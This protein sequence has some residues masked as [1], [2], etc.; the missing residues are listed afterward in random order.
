MN[1]TYL[2]I[3]TGLTLIFS[4]AAFVAFGTIS[5]PSPVSNGQIATYSYDDGTTISPASWDVTS[6][7][8]VNTYS[9][10]TTYYVVISWNVSGSAVIH[11]KE[12]GSVIDSK[13]VTINPCTTPV[14]IA[15]SGWTVCGGSSISISPVAAPGS[16]GTGVNW[17]S[18]AS[19][20]SLLSSSTTYSTVIAATTTYYLTTT[21][22]SC[23]SERTP[24]TVTLNP[25]P[26]DTPYSP[27]GASRCGA[28]D[29]SI[30][31]TK[32]SDGEFLWWYTAASGGSHFYSSN[33][34]L[35]II[36]LASTTTYY[37][38][39]ANSYGCESS[40]RLAVTATINPVPNASASNQT[41]CSGQSTSIAISNPNGV[42]GTT[43]SWTQSPLL[44]SGAS[45]G[46]GSTIAQALSCLSNVQGTV[47]YTITPATSLCSGTPINVTATV[48]PVPTVAASGQ[49]LYSG[50]AT[51][52][53][54]T[55]PNGV[56][57]TTFTW[58]QSATNVTGAS[59]G[60][61]TTITQ[62]LGSPINGS[63]VYTITPTANGCT[64]SPVVA[65]VFVGSNSITTNTVLVD[66]VTTSSAVDA[67]AIGSKAQA[68]QYFDGIGR[69]IQT[70]NTKGSPA[71]YDMV[72][73]QV[74]DVFGREPKNYLPFVSTQTTGYYNF[75]PTLNSGGTY[76]GSVHANFYNNS[77]DK[78]EDDTKPYAETI[79]EASP[80]NRV[81]K[82]GAPG[83]AWQPDGTWTYASTDA[84]IKR[85]YQLNVANEVLKWT[86]SGSASYSPLGLIDAGTASSKIY[87]PANTLP[88]NKSKDEHGNEVIEY[89]DKDGHVVL[90]RVQAVGG[91]S[92]VDDNN[93]ASTYYIYSDAGDL[94]CVVPPEATSRLSAEY[95]QSGATNTTKE[96]FLQRWAFRYKYDARKR[97]ALKQ[98][99][100]ADSMRMVYDVRDRVV[101][102]QD[103]NLRASNKWNYTEYDGLNRPIITGLYTHGSAVTQTQMASLVTGLTNLFETY[104]G[105]SSTHGYTNTVFPSG[106]FNVSGFEV[107]TVTYYDN[108]SFK[109]MLADSQ[110]DYVSNDYTD[111]FNIG[112]NPNLNVR[113]LVTG[114]KIKILDQSTYLWRATYFDD[115]NRVVQTIANNSKGGVDRNTSVFDFAGRML[116]NMTIHKVGTVTHTSA[117]HMDYD[118]G[119]RLLRTWHK[120]DTQPDIVLNESQY[121]ELGQL[122]KKSLHAQV[123]PAINSPNT[124]YSPD[125]LT[126]SIYSGQPLAIGRNSVTLAPG[127]DTG[128]GNSFTARTEYT[129][130]NPPS[131]G[132]TYRFAQVIDY[133]YNIRGWLKNINNSNLAAGTTGDPRDFFGMELGYNTNIG[134]SGATLAY[135]G[136]I[137]AATWSVNMA[138]DTLTQ[139][140]YNYKYDPLNRIL[141]A[142]HKE[143]A[144][145]TWSS[146]AAFTERNYAY[147]LNGNIKRLTRFGVGG[148]M[149][150]SLTYDYGTTMSNQLMKVSDNSDNAKGF[151][152]PTSTS[153][154]DYAYDPNG[155]MVTDQNKTL[156]ATNAVQ[157]N[158][159]NLAKLVTQGSGK[160]LKYYYD[161]SG[162]KFKQ[163]L[164]NASNVLQKKTEYDGEYVYENDTLKFIN[165]EDGR[166]IMTGSNP[167]Y[168]YHLKDHLGNVRSTFTTK[169]AVDVFNATL[170][171]NAQTTEQSQFLRYSRVTNDLYDHTDAGTV[172]DKV[173]LLNGGYNSQIGLAKSFM[174][175][176]GDTVKAE[177]YA[178]YFGTTGGGSNLAA[179]AAAL[180]SAFN[181][182]TPGVGETG[183]ASAAINNH[184]AW[185]ASNHHPGN[186]SWPE[187][188]LNILVF[189]RNYR[190]V[191][192]AY[193]QLDAS[194]VQTGSTKSPHQLLSKTV[195]IKKA[196][197]VYIYVSNESAVQQDI[198]FDDMKISY[199]KSP[200]I[201]TDDYYPFGLA[202]N[203]YQRE[204]SLVNNYQYNG[205]E[206]QDEFNLGWLDYG[207]RIYMPELGRWSSPDFLSEVSADLTPYRY[208][209]N[210]PLRFLDPN[211]LYETDGHYWTVYLM[212]MLQGIND[213]RGLAH[214]TE[215][216][217]SE[218]SEDGDIMFSRWTWAD[219]IFSQMSIHALTGGLSETERGISSSDWD[220]TGDGLS[221]HRYG[222][223]FAHTMW[224]G[225]NMYGPGPGHLR[226]WHAPDKIA[227]RPALYMQYVRGLAQLFSRKFGP[228]NDI[229]LFTFEYIAKTKGSTSQNCAIFETE[230]RIR[231]GACNFT[232]NG[233]HDGAINDYLLKS[234]SH[235]RRSANARVESYRVKVFTKAGNRWIESDE[236]KTF[237]SF[238]S[239]D[240]SPND[241]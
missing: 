240:H 191:D 166:I 127:F 71:Q 146:T 44:V 116:N 9:S 82:Q 63:V 136:N 118:A 232:V 220:M 137:S 172:Y 185:V 41:I 196:G 164:Y 113:A 65:T 101:F 102:T 85:A 106:T 27:V 78:I 94:V 210:N 227:E 13:S 104:N 148:A 73:P 61:G 97:M 228:C 110:F 86:W 98:V 23:E 72:Q 184:G 68:I 36:G 235:F 103:G 35:P 152:E 66:N 181:L 209:F 117:R 176:P 56:S 47:T 123:D 237:V 83:N 15:V 80:V 186:N 26:Q 93:Y 132:I 4:V 53:A 75:K 149:I 175:M 238:D 7:D 40:G 64:G 182:P 236:W 159:M 62:S 161:A 201:Q 212:G 147:D 84:T 138:L 100:G 115:K 70:V 90:K 187:G 121:N 139:R 119:G 177:V 17:Y 189:D 221:L 92:A 129:T 22:A 108:Y 125:D 48:K 216:P 114:T 111:Q 74:Y 59:N 107:L 224:D 46:S 128:T 11:F 199:T 124:S 225:Q 153:G 150:D 170:E 122:V 192:A 42:S 197:Y 43:F 16:G 179:M 156:T 230:I 165:I 239:N 99:P 174:V 19:G 5:G 18:A 141:E 190:L 180:L 69:P 29:I 31:A 211:G 144:V 88:R 206:K 89:T 203:E 229:D 131:G 219:P 169:R 223:S 76:T 45:S 154:N 162:R 195:Y 193:Q 213:A 20:G 3:K 57:G 215:W 157:Y 188:W 158:H 231:E 173:Q 54:I 145:T 34:T 33:S 171:D 24:M 202:F 130:S 50:D 58:T 30:S 155:N 6:G 109:T 214:D 39:T 167:E 49:T 81:I 14:P 234:N 204:N 87:Y 67:L 12:S 96:A 142:R 21:G 38:S 79:F 198:Y 126:L 105:T 1:S 222:D 112:G 194:Y 183:T 140:A 52:I 135:N 151:I 25:K 178:K 10:G 205:K 8:I 120:I 55:S 160:Y 134:N 60:S 143:L 241:H 168:Q 233:K 91:T 51:S 77:T 207:R 2:T 217:D 163:E 28:G 200:V 218:M 95:F 133:R 226:D 208:G 37:A 32:G